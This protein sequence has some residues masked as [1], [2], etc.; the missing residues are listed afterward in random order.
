M[1]AIVKLLGGEGIVWAE[2]AFFLHFTL[3]S[4]VVCDGV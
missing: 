1:R 2:G 4:R 3:S